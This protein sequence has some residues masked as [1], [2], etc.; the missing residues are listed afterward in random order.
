MGQRV[1]RGGYSLAY[2]RLNGVN[3][4][5]VPLLGPGPLQSV[6]CSAPLS[7]DTCGSSSTVG[8]AF[9]IGP[10]GLVAPLGAPTATLPQPYLPG[11]TENGILNPAAAD[12]T[13]LDPDY[14]PEKVH[15]FDFTSQRNFGRKISIEVGY[16][17]KKA[18][19]IFQ[20]INLDS[21]PYMMTAGG[22]QFSKA[23]ANMY[24]AICGWPNLRK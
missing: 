20:E 21:V 17:G 15:S 5:L 3:L 23:W 16:I 13:V 24:I 7:N 4:V 22:Q 2:G 18:T 10:D 1:I 8:N 12:S 19:N 6:T 14:K 11:V 9:R